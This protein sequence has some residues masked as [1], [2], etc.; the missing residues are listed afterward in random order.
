MKLLV[1]LVV[2]LPG[3]AWGQAPFD[4]TWVTK[5]D[6]IKT[7]GKPST[8]LVSDGM[9]SCDS[10]APALKIKADGSNQKVSGHA[11]F[12]TASARVLDA[13]RV[14]F[15]THAAGKMV[16]KQTYT[17]AADGK[18]MVVDFVDY[19]GIKPASG[20]VKHDRVAPA[21]AGAH[22][23]S[24]SWQLTALGSNFSAD[25]LTV[26]YTETPGGLKMS[27]PTGQSYDAKFDGKEYLTAGDPGKTMVSL[28][29]IDARTI[30][31]TDSR[32]DKVTDVVRSTVSTDGKSMHV[33]DED[34]AH[35]STTKFTME[36]KSS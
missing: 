3:V 23:L 30:E 15:I 25:L 27:S 2:L 14:E 29:R 8:Y 32:Q 6:S 7:T 36:K 19:T 35:G 31:E 5:I 4:G 34:K 17:V 10:C 9:F 11:Y 12:D 18:T 21:P 22:G 26:T 20:S 28:K 24:G 1:A 16:D 13:Q 33:V